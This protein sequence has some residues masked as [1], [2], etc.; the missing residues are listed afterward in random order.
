MQGGG[1]DEI[2][3]QLFATGNIFFMYLFENYKCKNIIVLFHAALV[4]V[5]KL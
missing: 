5:L 1:V 4:I 2:T 3:A